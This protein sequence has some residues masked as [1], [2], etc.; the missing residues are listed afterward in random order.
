MNS[1][2]KF[3]SIA[4]SY[5]YMSV[6]LSPTSTPFDSNSQAAAR[7][8]LM[9]DSSLLF[10]IITARLVLLTGSITTVG[11]LSLLAKG[12]D[13]I[14]ESVRV[15]LVTGRDR[16]GEFVPFFLQGCQGCGIEER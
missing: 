15:L 12:I 2:I 14:G 5:I 3:S 4:V 11:S 16:I 7:S 1:F 8:L 13:H 6:P 10:G 9:T